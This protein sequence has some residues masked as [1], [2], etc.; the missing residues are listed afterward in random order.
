MKL[1]KRIQFSALALVISAAACGT[2]S[3]TTSVSQSA[4]HDL[5]S[6]RKLLVKCDDSHSAEAQLT[7]ELSKTCRLQN[8]QLKAKG[9]AAC[10]ED[11]C[12]DVVSVS[13]EPRGLDVHLQADN[14]DIEISVMVSTNLQLATK[15]KN[16]LICYAP[17]LK[18]RELLNSLGGRC[19]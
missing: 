13:S 17:V 2:A 1:S 6:T 10:A 16:M 7:R 19:K 5:E 15:E 3:E 11:H 18:A 14:K 9:F 4:Q 12:S 8:A